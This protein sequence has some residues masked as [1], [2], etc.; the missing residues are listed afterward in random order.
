MTP[1]ELDL[2]VVR[3]KLAAIEDSLD[4]LE[5][6][7]EVTATLLSED[8]IIAAAVERLLSRIVDL[9]VDINSH[10]VVAV[11]G[12]SPGAYAES[13]RMATKMGVLD[14]ELGD[15]LVG[16]VGMR[17]VIVH[18]YVDLDHVIVAK[19]VPEALECYRR[20]VSAVAR[21]V[22]ERQRG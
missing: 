12:R 9:A 16:S 20:Y 15:R 14:P 1:P 3:Q 2:D 22:L 19:A 13:F 17:N 10:I 11:S 8:A 21:F 5:S 7:H 4:S 6:L 18:Q